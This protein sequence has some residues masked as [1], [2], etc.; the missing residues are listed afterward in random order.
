MSIGLAQ[1]APELVRESRT[2]DWILCLGLVVAYA[3]A[4][5]CLRMA[6]PNTL[7]S[8]ESEQVVFSQT[9]L[10]GYSQQPPL[11]TWLVWLF[12]QAFGMSLGVLV[13]LRAL[14]LACICVFHFLFARSVLGEQRL[15]AL[16]TFALLL[17]YQLSTSMLFDN[18]HTM[19]LSAVGM[20]T[21]YLFIHLAISGR[22]IYYVL[23]G[24]VLGLGG[25]SKYNYA[26]LV[27]AFLV[28]G[29]SL[30]PFRARLLDARIVLTI[31]LAAALVFPHVHWLVGHRALVYNAIAERTQ[32]D[33]SNSF[34][35]AA[36]LGSCSLASKSFVIL[37]PLWLIFLIIFPQGLRS[38]LP[39]DDARRFLAR[40]FPISM[41]TMLATILT[42]GATSVKFR[43]VQPFLMLFPIYYLGRL[44]A[45]AITPAKLR[46][47]ACSVVVCMLIAFADVHG[48]RALNSSRQE[49]VFGVPIML[50]YR[51]QRSYH[52]QS[53]A[54]HANQLTAAGFRGGTIIAGDCETAGKLRLLFPHDRVF[55]VEFV[56]FRPPCVDPWGQSVVVWRAD[57][58]RRLPPDLEAYVTGELG[59][60]LPPS[61]TYLFTDPQV[62]ASALFPV[63]LGFVLLNEQPD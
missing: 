27:G 3:G 33:Q 23:L 36:L 20:A 43:H 10:L 2:R 46:T 18:T 62:P 45:P 59:L 9:L 8:D 57:E 44:A 56:A 12:F 54:G 16:A 50:E 1:H 40:L 6:W 25:L 60:A 55:C 24:L 28:A 19:L 47:L 13:L 41:A 61:E 34:P 30:K 7:H 53:F 4:Y 11:Y 52:Y 32:V 39:S 63:R 58:D 37:S 22:T 38:R 42:L 48:R 29:L 17:M 35:H 15:A 51:L 5:L 26:V 49:G 31:L 14:I 21:G